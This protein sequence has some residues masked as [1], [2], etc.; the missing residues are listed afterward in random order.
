MNPF[1]SHF[2]AKPLKSVFDLHFKLKSKIST[3][4][5]DITILHL[6]MLRDSYM[7]FLPQIPNISPRGATQVRC[8]STRRLPALVSCPTSYFLHVLIVYDLVLCV[9]FMGCLVTSLLRGLWEFHY[10]S[11]FN[12]G[13]DLHASLDTH[14]EGCSTGRGDELFGVCEGE[15]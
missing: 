1:L 12:F 10:R 5:R 8:E 15:L 14:K 3:F 11:L 13:D 9:L 7:T 4:N 2:R 6:K